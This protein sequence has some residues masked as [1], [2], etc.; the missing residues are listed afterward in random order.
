MENRLSSALVYSHRCM[1]PHKSNRPKYGISDTI[2]LREHQ[3][4][5]T[6][7][8]TLDR[9]MP[10]ECRAEIDMYVGYPN[11][12]WPLDVQGRRPC[13]RVFS[14]RIRSKAGGQHYCLT[15]SPKED[16]ESSDRWAGQKLEY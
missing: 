10:H 2:A 14:G 7:A 4:G 12:E 5:V 3:A 8:P 6:A 9:K 16:F 1:H 15:R 13:Y 11:Y